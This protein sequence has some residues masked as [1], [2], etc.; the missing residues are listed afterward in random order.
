MYFLCM[1][2]TGTISIG[3]QIAIARGEKRLTQQQLAEA[4]GHAVRTIAAWEAGERTPR[5]R[6]LELLARVLGQEVSWFY[7][8]QES[9]DRRAA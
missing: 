2:Q 3:R 1:T 5:L 7:A 6:H 4:T 8:S 9:T